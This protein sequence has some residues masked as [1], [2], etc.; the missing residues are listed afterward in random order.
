MRICFSTF[1]LIWEELSS[2]EKLSLSAE[3]RYAHIK[4]ENNDCLVVSSYVEER[5]CIT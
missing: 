2:A 5:I 1:L 3:F 4:I